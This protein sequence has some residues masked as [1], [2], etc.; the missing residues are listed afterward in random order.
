QSPGVWTVLAQERFES[1]RFPD[2]ESLTEV[3][4]RQR[5]S[6]LTDGL[7]RACFSVAG[8]V[9]N[10]VSRLTNLPWVVD[11]AE[12][13]RSLGIARVDVINDFHAV[14]LGIERL[15]GQDLAPLNHGKIEPHGPIAVIGAGTGL[16]EAVLVWDGSQYVAVPSEG[17]HVEFGPRNALELKLLD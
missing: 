4:L 13:S 12:L 11:K 17:G 15:S 5:G 6:G 16:G 10:G 14:A 7:D 1:G 3:F 8:P 2:L 9:K